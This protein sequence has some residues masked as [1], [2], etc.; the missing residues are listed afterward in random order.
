MKITIIGAGNIGIY[1]GGFLLNNSLDVTFLGRDRINK[2][3]IEND[4]SLSDLKGFQIKIPYAKLNYKTNPNELAKSDIYIITVK[5]QDTKSTLN[6]LKN[7]IE[8]KNIIISLQ[9]GVS[10]L[11]FIKSIYPNN[12]IISGMIPFNI[13]NQSPGV[14]K[15]TTSGELIFQNSECNSIINNLFHNSKLSYKFDDNIEGILYGKLIFNLN[16]PINAL[17]NLPLR[18]ELLNPE[19]RIILSKCINEA[20]DV[21]SLAKIK[22]KILGKMI[23]WLAPIVLR[24]PNWLFSRV[25][26]NM[27]KID[28]Y[29]R[30]SMWEDLKNL[31]TTEI[32]YI[33]GEILKLANKFNVQT[34]YNSL[35]YNL[36]KEAEKKNIGS[37]SITSSYILNKIER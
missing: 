15:C 11:E 2:E 23:P 6:S 33:T 36:I 19:F 14:Y 1:I 34:P 32:E 20:L 26:S 3:L 37:P 7:T 30:S 28:P 4:L 35:I 13:F 10:N 8:E 27:I 29:A 18:E 24:L 12:I 16:N 22:P 25:A 21:Y 17:C 5:S 9:N 31:K